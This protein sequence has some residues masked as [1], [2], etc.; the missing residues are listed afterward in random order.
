[1]TQDLV[2]IEGVDLEALDQEQE[3]YRKRLRRQ[4]R[5]D[6]DTVLSIGGK[7]DQLRAIPDEQ[8]QAAVDAD[9]ETVEAENA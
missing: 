4:M 3:K 7:L 2:D 6:L 1:M 5:A 8:W 9:A